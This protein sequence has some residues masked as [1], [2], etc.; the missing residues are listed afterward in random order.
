MTRWDRIERFVESVRNG[1]LTECPDEVARTL[2]LMVEAFDE[3][4]TTCREAAATLRG[5]DTPGMVLPQGGEGVTE[6]PLD[7]RKEDHPN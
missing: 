3:M 5:A 4:S 1:T 2:D 7:G 6:S